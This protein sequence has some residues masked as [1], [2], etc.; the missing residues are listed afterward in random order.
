MFVAALTRKGLVLDFTRRT[1]TTALR[2]VPLVDRRFD[3]SVSIAVNISP[4]AL[5]DPE[6]IDWAVSQF[7]AESVDPSRI[8]FEITEDVFMEDLT[9]V[10][11][12]I[13]RLRSE[14]IKVSLDDSG[15]GYSSLSY[16][17][18]LPLAEVKA[19]KTFVERI[20]DDTKALDLFRAIS[21]MAETLGYDLV[22]EG[23]ETR[24]QLAAIRT[25]SCRIAQGYLFGKPEPLE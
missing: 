21:S 13:R 4:V 6:F 12:L 16:V 25:T 1:L 20:N 11:S 14:G 7:Q 15:T 9:T 23:V 19:D 3:A 8:M 5:L 17:S 10:D 2:H 22:A 18:G 24:E